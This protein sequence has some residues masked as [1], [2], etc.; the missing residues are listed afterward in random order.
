MSNPD[1]PAGAQVDPSEG[2]IDEG[3]E[4]RFQASE[5]EGEESAALE[6]DPA[7]AELITSAEASG[8]LS[9]ALRS[10]SDTESVRT[11]SERQSGTVRIFR[12]G[13]SQIVTTQ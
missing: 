12:F 10:M 4:Q 2:A 1:Q 13:R 9:L 8:T 3:E 5:A 7:E 6:V 11:A